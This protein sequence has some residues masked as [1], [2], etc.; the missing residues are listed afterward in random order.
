M[1][2]WQNVWVATCL[3]VKMSRCQN[4]GCQ[5]VHVSKYWVSKCPCVKW[6]CAQMSEN[7]RG[8]PSTD[9]SPSVDQS[10]DS[11][12]S[13]DISREDYTSILAVIEGSIC[14]PPAPSVLYNIMANEFVS[15]D[16]KDRLRVAARSGRD[17]NTCLVSMS[18][19]T[20]PL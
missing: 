18:S 15:E 6:S 1:P 19:V 5:N 13:S 7:H 10:T 14:D 9:A 8:D 2:G 4:V 12:N 16:Y 3:V 17:S 11:S 20:C